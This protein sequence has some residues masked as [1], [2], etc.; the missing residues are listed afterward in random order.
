MA[1]LQQWG[2][3][4][5]GFLPTRTMA[6]ADGLFEKGLISSPRTSVSALPKHLKRH[7]ERRFPEAKGY[8]FLSEEQIPYCHGILT[9]ERAPLFL[10]EDEQRIYQMIATNVEMTFQSQKFVEVGI[11]ANIDGMDFY[12]TA[13]PRYR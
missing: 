1:T 3:S 2:L 6:A 7:I 10:T 13:E 4:E 5:C 8:D 9:T 11:T 12:G